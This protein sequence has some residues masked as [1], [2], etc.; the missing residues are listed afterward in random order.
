MFTG[1]IETIGRIEFIGNLG[2]DLGG[3]KRLVVEAS[4]A[5]EVRIDQSIA[6]NGTCLTVVAHTE[7]NFRVE[8]I[9]ETLRKTALGTLK[10]GSS[11]NLERAMLPTTRL[12]GHFVQGHVDTVGTVRHIEQEETSWLFTIEFPSEYRPYLIPV[13][14]ITVDGISLTVARLTANMLTVAIIPY[15]YQHTIISTWQIGQAVNLEF[16]MMG[17]YVVGW[18]SLRDQ[19]QTPDAL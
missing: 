9:E 15:T 3:G 2:E 6:V 13:G 11:V 7:R 5:N 17:K 4:F 16:D 12:D 10:Q 18:L 19:N 14:S 8:V 1:I